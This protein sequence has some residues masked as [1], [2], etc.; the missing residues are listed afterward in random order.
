M[1]MTDWSTAQRWQPA[2]VVRPTTAQEAAAILAEAARTGTTVRPIGSGHSFTPL[3]VT[4]GTQVVLDGM[5]GLVGGPD[6]DGAVR[7]RGGT[8][9]ALLNTLLAARGRA[10][11]NLGDIDA[12][13]IAG[14]I[15]TGTHGT[16][17]RFGGLATQVSAL[18]LALPDGSVRRCDAAHDP[19][20]FQAARLGV[21]AFGLITEVTLDTVPAFGLYAVERPD[22]LSTVLADLPAHLRADHFEFFW[23]P[24]TDRVLAKTNT[25]V[26]APEAA[27][28]G[29]P[30]W[31]AYLDDE[32]LANRLFE[33]VN[34]GCAR[35]PAATPYLNQVAA[36]S[37]P[38]R[39]YT[40]PSHQVFASPRTVRF[41]ESEYAVPVAAVD[42]VLRELRR[43]LERSGERVAFPVEVRFAAADQVWLSTSYQRDSAYVAVHMYHRL[44]PSRFFGAFEDIVA[45]Y[46]GRPHWG[47]MHRLTA[48]DLQGRYPRFGDA[49]AVRDRV[50]PQRVLGSPYLARVLDA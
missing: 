13:T 16:G 39:S 27:S 32:L 29:L 18:E 30:A 2:A 3:A 20:L 17:A 5:I 45:R 11:A 7:V 10:V 22:R 41:R 12:Q 48:A 31:R 23:F 4:D 50:D 26:A 44:D 49:L 43:W 19:D 34:R 14:A 25:R 35:W 38:A 15:S 6:P 47:K 24:H 40:A 37:L 28:S 36:R 1:R 46:D 8:T 33:V 42:D 9:L 21:G